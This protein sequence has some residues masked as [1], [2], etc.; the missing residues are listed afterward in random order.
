MK[1]SIVK[2]SK[3]CVSLV[4]VNLL[5]QIVPDVILHPQIEKGNLGK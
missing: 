3:I 5:H 2:F 4:V 1:F